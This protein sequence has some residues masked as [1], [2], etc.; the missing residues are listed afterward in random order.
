MAPMEVD[1]PYL[2]LEMFESNAGGKIYYLI[3]EEGGRAVTGYP[4]L[5]MPSAACRTRVLSNVRFLG[6]LPLF[7]GEELRMGDAAPAGARRTGCPDAR[8]AGSWSA[9]Q[10]SRVRRSLA[11]S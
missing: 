5:P 10:S 7:R 2:A 9:K 4:D 11:R 6:D 8:S 1:L 3:R